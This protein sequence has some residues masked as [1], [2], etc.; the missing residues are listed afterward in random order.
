MFKYT[1][2]SATSI[3]LIICIFFCSELSAMQIDSLTPASKG[4]MI[5]AA[6]TV[7]LQ[8]GTE[9]TLKLEEPV[10]SGS[11]WVNKVVQMSVYGDIIIDNDVI[12]STNISAEG[13]ITDVEEPKGFGRPAKMTI[14]ARS[15]RAV[16]GTFVPLRGVEIS[17]KGKSKKAVTC[18]GIVAAVIG[19]AAGVPIA[20]ALLGSGLMEKGGQIEIGK[21]DVILFKAR[22]SED[23]FIKG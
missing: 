9:I 2:V 10:N 15:V 13:I 11:S 8:K 19:T 4:E 3:I 17:P 22:I 16:D 6:R 7:K 23:V 12:I 5:A 1:I 18:L 20:L 14:V 21:E